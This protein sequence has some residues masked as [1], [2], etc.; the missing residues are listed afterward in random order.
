MQDDLLS[1]IPKKRTLGVHNEEVSAV[2]L[3]TVPNAGKKEARYGV[4]IAYDSYETT[5]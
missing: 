5:L 4:F 2:L 3:V 1:L